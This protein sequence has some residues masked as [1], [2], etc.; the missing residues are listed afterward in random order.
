[1]INSNNSE[2]PL[3]EFPSQ[4][5]LSFPFKNYK[6]NNISFKNSVNIINSEKKPNNHRQYL[7]DFIRDNN[8]K[9]RKSPAPKQMISNKNKS[10]INSNS[11]SI[12]DNNEEIIDKN[13]FFNDYFNQQMRFEKINHNKYNVDKLMDICDYIGEDSKRPI[14]LEIMN[15]KMH[16]FIPGRIS[17]KSFG[18]INSYAANTNQGID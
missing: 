1:M 6:P 11:N 2:F 16:N 18:L 17:S 9:N 13:I 10:K 7:I 12:D 8:N 5:R 4:N 14:N 15:V 3:G